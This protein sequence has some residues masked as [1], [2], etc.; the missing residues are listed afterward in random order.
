MA[1]CYLVYQGY[2]DPPIF[3]C[4]VQFQWVMESELP[5]F[6]FHKPINPGGILAGIILNLYISLVRTDIIN[7]WVF[8]FLNMVYHSIYL[9][10]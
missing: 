9:G 10:A 5:E 8:L 6:N 3:F 2:C 4:S 1:A 7:I